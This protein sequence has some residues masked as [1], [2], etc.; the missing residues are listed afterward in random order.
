MIK[1][2]EN[3]PSHNGHKPASKAAPDAPAAAEGKPDAKVEPEASAKVESKPP[4][5]VEPPPGTK[6]EP[7]AAPAKPAQS[8]WKLTA[9][10]FLFAASIVGFL[11]GVIAAYIFGIKKAPLPPAFA[12][13]VNP[14]P[15]GI[16]SEG[17]IES[18]QA[19][20][21][22]INVF[23]EVTG[24]VVS[25]PVTEGQEVRK[26]TPLVL[27]DDSVPRAQAEAA[28][29]VLKGADDTL[30]KLAAAVKLNSGTVPRDTLDTAINT[31][32][33]ARANL[34]SANALLS[35]YTL[36]ATADGVV[37]TI[38][39]A[40]NSFVSA[41][42]IYD[43]YTQGY[44]P[45]LIIG[46]PQ[47]DLHVRCFVDEILVAKLPSPRTI[48]AQLALR[49]SDL[50]IPLQFVRVQ[51]FVSPKIELSDQRTERVDV[52]VLPV[53]FRFAKP[54]NVNIFPGQLVDVYIG[55]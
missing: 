34:A 13:V 16:Y 47:A 15:N 6:T 31:A 26:G 39:A 1:H 11:A 32:A 27:L 41:Q 46:T 44:D 4:A 14:Y 23:A 8:S 24:V 38:N 3:P 45:V 51:P 2:K 25:V 33:T 21:S 12:P 29:A 37:M 22:N 7:E 9:N 36:R 52:R 18:A 35:K 20:G 40:V 55:E 50:R 42:G 10:K 17:I 48:R 30:A 5:K 19:N 43:S 53:V 49:G 54:S 28:R